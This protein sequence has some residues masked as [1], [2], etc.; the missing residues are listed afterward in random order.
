MTHLRQ[1]HDGATVAPGELFLRTWS[2]LNSGVADWPPGT[3]L[4][5]AS[6]SHDG[7]KAVLIRQIGHLLAC[8][9]GC[10]DPAAVPANSD[11]KLQRTRPGQAALFVVQVQAPAETGEHEVNLHLTSGRGS[12]W[13]QAVK[14]RFSVVGASPVSGN[15]GPVVALPPP[16]EN[17]ASSQPDTTDDG[18]ADDLLVVP[19]KA[20]LLSR[21]HISNVATDHHYK[22]SLCKDVVATVGIPKANA[23]ALLLGNGTLAWV[24]LESGLTRGS[25]ADCQA[26]EPLCP[27]YCSAD[28]SA[29]STAVLYVE[30][31]MD[32]H[33]ISAWSP[34][35]FAAA[36]VSPL[37]KRIWPFGPTYMEPGLPSLSCYD[38]FSD[39]RSSVTGGSGD[40][41]PQNDDT[42]PC[43]DVSRVP[44]T[45]SPGM[46]SHGLDWVVPCL[47]TLSLPSECMCISALADHALA[48]LCS[49]GHI[50][51]YASVLTCPTTRSPTTSAGFLGNHLV[52]V[53]Q[54]SVI[55]CSGLSLHQPLLQ[56][57]GV[58][59]EPVPML[60]WFQVHSGSLQADFCYDSAPPTLFGDQCD[61]TVFGDEELPSSVDAAKAPVVDPALRLLQIKTA[62][63]VPA[64]SDS[65]TVCSVASAWY[66]CWLEFAGTPALPVYHDRERV[67]QAIMHQREATKAWHLLVLATGPDHWM[68]PV[69][70]ALQGDPLSYRLLKSGSPSQQPLIK[71]LHG[72]LLARF[73]ADPTASRQLLSTSPASII[74]NSGDFVLGTNHMGLGC[75]IVGR[76]LEAVRVLLLQQS[77]HHGVWPGNLP[78]RNTGY[79]NAVAGCHSR[80]LDGTYCSRH[81]MSAATISRLTKSLA[82]PA[83]NPRLLQDPTTG[84]SLGPLGPLS[85]ILT[86]SGRDAETHT[87][88]LGRTSTLFQRVHKALETNADAVRWLKSTGTDLL[89]YSHVPDAAQGTLAGGNELGLA[90]MQARDEMQAPQKADHQHDHDGIGCTGHPDDHS[91]AYDQSPKDTLSRMYPE[92]R[93]W[94][95]LIPAGIG[96]GP[97]SVSVSAAGQDT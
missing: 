22:P 4:V 3:H 19:G 27:L 61:D 2:M 54:S 79:C 7:T 97:T 28:Q 14:L 84:H 16:P 20:I 65:S 24:H 78:N 53:Y 55:G 51:L 32:G 75:N 72:I 73:K 88:E 40:Q 31:Q 89:S 57:P 21:L 26:M 41:Q 44:G 86:P 12:R 87:G 80:A 11:F 69:H 59:Q 81:A 60:G 18:T 56:G 45:P 67:R 68:H 38:M 34:S 35:S 39:G 49:N 95:S 92:M 36:S 47:G 6:P 64:G 23:V 9:A 10:L 71:A 52:L 90:F 48:V 96:G 63:S 66:S 74:Y 50:L 1:L 25:P 17:P 91:S 46:P 70:N 37:F 77:A 93:G 85:A 76:A 5:D 94:S 82:G 83:V 43:P 30:Q 58:M 15:Y 8:Q 62:F 42:T 29:E 13:G 33:F